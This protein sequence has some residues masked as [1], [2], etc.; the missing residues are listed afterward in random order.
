MTNEE[1]AESIRRARELLEQLDA[2]DAARAARSAMPQTCVVAESQ[3]TQSFGD[4][5]LLSSE[6]MRKWR[7]EA[8]EAEAR[9]AQYR[10]RTMSEL[11][12]QRTKDWETWLERHLEFEREAILKAAGQAVGMIRAQLRD[13][14][15][16]QLGQLRAE[17]NMLRSADK[18]DVVTL[19]RL[20]LYRRT[21]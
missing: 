11:N 2:E 17:F 15:A 20:P 19:P 9:R 3:L 18:A 6:P 12:A 4:M 1:K 5:P 21:G 10:E 13:E 7:A 14:F 16:E 8:E